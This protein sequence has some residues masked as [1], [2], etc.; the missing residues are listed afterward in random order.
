MIR[1]PPRSTL[2]PYTTLFRSCTTRRS[3]AWSA[4]TR[5]STSSR[6]SVPRSASCSTPGRSCTAPVKAP[7]AC[8]K[9]S[10]SASVSG[11][12]AQLT[13]RKGTV[14][15]AR[16]ARLR[17]ARRRREQAVDFQLVLRHHDELDHVSQHT[18]PAGVVQTIEACPD[19]L[20]APQDRVL[21]RYAA[22]GGGGWRLRLGDLH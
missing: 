9:N 15:A 2:F 12:A 8:P 10:L 19:E 7:R 17:L 1:R 5:S 21:A 14:A 13:G 3:F 4:G 20:H 18:G 16:C 6:K 11:T 22:R